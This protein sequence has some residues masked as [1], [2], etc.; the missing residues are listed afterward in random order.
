MKVARWSAC[1]VLN[2]LPWASLAGRRPWS[3]W[4]GEGFGERQMV[5]AKSVMRDE[6]EQ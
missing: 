2:I 6:G 1:H 5:P 3:L 4:R